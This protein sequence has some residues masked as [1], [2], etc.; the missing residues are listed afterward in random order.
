MSLQEIEKSHIR[1]GQEGL[2]REIDKSSQKMMLDILQITQYAK[3][4]LSTVRELAS[5]AVDAQK[6][7]EVALKILKKEAKPE[8]Y[9]HTREGEQYEASRW[10]PSYYSLKYLDTINNHVDLHYIEGQGQG[11]C[12]QFIVTDYGVGLGG[13]R[14]KGYFKLGFSSKRNSANA[15]GAFGEPVGK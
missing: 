9:Y 13:D 5:N 12:D 8:D 3:P 15:F 7:K 4:I 11:F 2:D 14:L 6:E 1:S 10:D